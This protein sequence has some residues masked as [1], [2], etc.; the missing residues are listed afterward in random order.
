MYR[1]S[2][3]FIVPCAWFSSVAFVEGIS[4]NFFRLNLVV[5]VYLNFWTWMFPCLIHIFTLFTHR[6]LCGT[7]LTCGH[8]NKF[9]N[10]LWWKVWKLS[11]LFV[12]RLW[13]TKSNE[14]G[15]VILIFIH[16]FLNEQP[17]SI[18]I[19]LYRHW[20]LSDPTSIH[21]IF[22]RLF[23][24]FFLLLFGNVLNLLLVLF[25]SNKSALHMGNSIDL[26][27]MIE[28]RIWS[29]RHIQ[30]RHNIFN[31]YRMYGAVYVTVYRAIIYFC[32]KFSSFHR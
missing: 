17:N 32:L 13:H 23:C 3:F 8:S 31:I 7:Q 29:L 18:S 2:V 5:L 19:S 6:Q 21:T 26:F 27:W 28:I 25:C 9:S 14:R 1:L 16:F 10:G 12:L 22:T 20:P 30:Q 4:S 24:R 11:F 15:G